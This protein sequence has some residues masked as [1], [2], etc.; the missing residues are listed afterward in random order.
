VIALSMLLEDIL[1]LTDIAYSKA[2]GVKARPRPDTTA[3]AI[4]CNREQGRERKPL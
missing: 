1:A 4:R 3:N 2:A